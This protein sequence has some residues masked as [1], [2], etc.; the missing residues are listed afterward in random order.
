MSA[1]PFVFLRSHDALVCGMPIDTRIDEPSITGHRNRHARCDGSRQIRSDTPESPTARPLRPR[2]VMAFH[3]NQTIGIAA[4]APTETV[5]EA[6]RVLLEGPHSRRRE[7]WLV[8]RTLWEFIAGFRALHFVGPCV[9]VFGSARCGEGHPYYDIGRALGRRIAKLGFTVMTGGG[10][11][12]MEAANRGAKEAGGRSVG[13]NIR[14]P[15]EQAPNAYLDHWVTCRYFFVRK[16]LLFKYSYAKEALFRE[17]GPLQE[18]WAFAGAKFGWSQRLKR[19]KRVI[20]YLTPC[21]AHFLASFALGEKACAAARD[22]DL[23]VRIQSLL[24]DAPKYAEGRGVRIPVRTERDT[25]AIR[26]LAAIKLAH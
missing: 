1:S 18:E 3:T 11:G 6:D 23:P 15:S 21:K 17:C 7:L 16:V 10:P 20:I 8:L 4:A 14:L 2:G 26:I 9:T 19:G 25:K 22:A 13:C 12:L 5:S 24:A